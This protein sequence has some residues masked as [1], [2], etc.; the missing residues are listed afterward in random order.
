MGG[1]CREVVVLG[2]RTYAGGRTGSWVGMIR[3]L[4]GEDDR[5]RCSRS[6]AYEIDWWCIGCA[7]INIGS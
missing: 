4:G 3:R 6:V 2:R 1:D 7:I 5:T